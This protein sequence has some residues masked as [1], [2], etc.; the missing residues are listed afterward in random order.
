MPYEITLTNVTAGIAVSSGKPGERVSVAVRDFSSSEDGDAFIRLLE[1]FPS[2]LLARI[3][4]GISPRPSTIDHMLAVIRQDKTATIY[5]N[6]LPLLIT[7][8]L[9][10]NIKKK[11]GDLILVD[12]I[13]DIQALE[14]GIVLIPENAGVLFLFS[15]NWRKGLFYDFTSLRSDAEPRDYDFEALVGR[16]YGYL[17]FQDRFKLTDEEWQK[18]FEEQWFL[19]VTLKS[20]T[21][22]QMLNHVR[23]GW[24]VNDLLEK[25]SSE[26]TIGLNDIVAAWK[27]NP[28]F[29]PHIALLQHAVDRYKEQDFISSTAILYPRIEGIMRNLY[30]MA[31]NKGA[32]SQKNLVTSIVHPTGTDEHGISL[33][34]PQMFRKYLSD[35]YFQDFIPGK[36]APVSRNSVGHGVANPKDF[37]LK[38]ATIGLLIVDQL[39]YFLPIEH[40][41]S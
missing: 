6:E 30:E 13:V 19:F 28:L 1:G 32:M 5:V 38:N 21:I 16:Y 4:D 2:E 15:V 9:K 41:S 33:L 14:L 31:G 29:T 35:V 26:L 24:A 37:S 22:H 34:L 25:I 39:S 17:V 40:F 20:S 3:P 18:L 11:K 7:T 12:G 36:E 23:N 10:R 27:Q 8:Q